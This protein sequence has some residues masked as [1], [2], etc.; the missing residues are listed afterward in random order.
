MKYVKDFET[1][2]G[3]VQDA[4]IMLWEKRESIDTARNPKSYLTTAIY[5]RSLNYLRDNKKFDKNV[6][7]FEEII[8]NNSHSADSALLGKELK[9][10][11]DSAIAELPEKCREVFLLSRT[12][13]LKYQ[14]I[15]DTLQISIKTVEAQMSKALAHLRLRLGPYLP[16]LL[17]MQWG[18]SEIFHFFNN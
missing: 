15:A 9:A 4:F 17:L 16:L 7:E 1:A 18:F 8:D 10:K 6:V 12:E 14:Q 5:T 2:R 11:I 13:N 3:I